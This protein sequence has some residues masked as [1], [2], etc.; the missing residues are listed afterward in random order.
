MLIQKHIQ[1]LSVRML[2]EGAS[3]TSA[4]DRGRCPVAALR[5]A[6]ANTAP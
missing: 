2:L 3:K 4:D 1:V 5:A 6:R